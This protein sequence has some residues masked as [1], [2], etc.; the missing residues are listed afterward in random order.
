[1]WLCCSQKMYACFKI[2]AICA[3]LD[4]RL[5]EADV[6]RDLNKIG[7]KVFFFL[8]N[9]PVRDFREVGSY[10]ALYLSGH[11]KFIIKQSGYNVFPDEVEA[12]I[13]K[14]DGVD[15]LAVVGVPHRIV[16]IWPSHQPL[17][18]TRVVKVDKLEMSALAEKKMA[19]LREQGQWDQKKIESVPL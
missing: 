1:M 13:A 15:M 8:G 6:M 9:T 18:L 2:G 3:P 11:R 16:E 7:P 10:R 4:V 17:P 5:K 12:H 19:Q 14:L